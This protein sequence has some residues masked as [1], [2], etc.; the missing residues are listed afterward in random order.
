[1]KYVRVYHCW[2]ATGDLLYIGQ[3]SDW[4]GRRSNH[5]SISPWWSSVDHV[6]FSERMTPVDAL[7]FERQSIRAEAPLHNKQCNNKRFVLVGGPPGTLGGHHRYLTDEI[8]AL[9]TEAVS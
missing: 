3:T 1:M 7:A 2:S 9:R 4:V 6:T 5:A 8:E